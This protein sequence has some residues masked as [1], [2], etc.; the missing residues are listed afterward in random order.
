MIYSYHYRLIVIYFIFSVVF[1]YHFV[2]LVA[3][4]LPAWG[5]LLTL[6]QSPF[7]MQ[8]QSIKKQFFWSASLVSGS[9]N[10]AG[11]S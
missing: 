3:Q 2:Y 8:Y 5:I 6:L 1:Q 7:D 4:I 9:I 10:T 11:L